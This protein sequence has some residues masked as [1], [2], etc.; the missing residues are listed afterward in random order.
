MAVL[1]TSM[2]Q[3]GPLED[4]TEWATSWPRPIQLIRRPEQIDGVIALLPDKPP[5][6]FM[7]RGRTHVVI[8]ADGPE[9]ITGE[10]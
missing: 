1:V 4:A 7:W 9:R 10:W 2:A 6:R 3:I 5:K 8:C